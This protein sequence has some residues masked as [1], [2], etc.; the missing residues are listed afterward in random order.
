MADFSIS[1]GSQRYESVGEDTSGSTGTAVVANSTINTK[2]SWV[3]LIAS[4]S[5]DY[6]E[7]ILELMGRDGASVLVDIG[8]GA[9]ASE[10]VII[11]NI[12]VNL[13]G[14]GTG[15]VAS[16]APIPVKIPAGTRIAA[17]SQSD[18]SSYSLDVKGLGKGNTLMQSPGRGIVT[19]Y[20]ANVSDSR[21]ALVDCGATANTKGSYTEITASTTYDLTDLIVCLGS[22]NTFSITGTYLMDIAI[23]GAGSEVVIIPN[24]FLG[25]DGNFDGIT[26]G[27][28]KYEM[29]IPAGTRL[30]IRAQCTSNNTSTRTFN[31][32]LVGVT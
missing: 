26:P 31:A 29:G 23:G 32:A 12:P 7:F 11:P 9:A 10:V 24:V 8:I 27:L 28:I 4:T 1:G 15:A 17:R 18:S 19:T 20:G 30:A 2:G 16:I 5:F 3:E 6:E 25:S 13:N 21:G 14:T 22:I